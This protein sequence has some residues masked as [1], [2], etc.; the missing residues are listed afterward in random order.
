MDKYRI[1][2]KDKFKSFYGQDV[3]EDDHIIQVASSIMMTR[4]EVLNGGS[5]VTAFVKNN[6]DEA[7]NRADAET[8]NHFRYFSYVKKFGYLDEN[9]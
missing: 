5:F 3:K 2:A 8:I 7:V 9:I 1:L 6:L 4:D